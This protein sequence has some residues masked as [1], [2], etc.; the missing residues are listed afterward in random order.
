[1]LKYWIDGLNEVVNWIEGFIE[2]CNDGN[3]EWERGSEGWREG[4][5]LKRMDLV[6][7]LDVLLFFM[8]GNKDVLFL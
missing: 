7:F 5:V 1:M 6:G 4:F 2:F 3:M 8:F